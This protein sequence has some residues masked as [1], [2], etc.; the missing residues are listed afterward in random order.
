MKKKIIFFFFLL[1][2]LRCSNDASRSLLSIP[3]TAPKKGMPAS[4]PPADS[5]SFPLSNRDASEHRAVHK[6]KRGKKLLKDH[7]EPRIPEITAEKRDSLFIRRL[8]FLRASRLE[9]DMNEPVSRRFLF[10]P[11]ENQLPASMITLSGES[12]LSIN[13]DN[14][15]LDYTDRFYTNGIKIDLITPELRMN[16]LG[17]LM[18]PY[19]SGGKNYYGITVVQNMYTPSST[20][21]GGILYGDRPYSAYL[22]IGSF[23]I[24]MDPDHNFSQT[25]ELDIG[26]IGPKSFGEW[27]QRSFH[28]SV[29]TNHEPLGWEHQIKNDL[30]L[31]Y[32]LKMEKGIWKRKNADLTVISAA[33]AGTL[34]TNISGG[35]AFRAGLLNPYFMNPGVER[36]DKLRKT[37]LRKFQF[38][39]FI[40]GSGTVV[41]YDA[42][43][44][45]GLFNQTSPYTLKPKEISRVVFE[46]SS[47]ISVVL[48]GCRV[49]LEQFL[50]SPDFH[51]GWWHKWVH[52][53]LAFGL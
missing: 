32:S 16:P 42:T 10:L 35:G 30:V 48:N 51:N 28:R 12:F 22:Y 41:G 23:K 53:S 15:L 13:F 17:K 9:P 5:R 6:G 36:K 25:S 39:F 26:I 40:K 11:L 27:V 3:D 8:L 45:G 49:D 24:T 43:L 38:Y 34:Y 4:M 46:S 29:P 18:I 2:F 44:E 14:D 1:L 50:L 37:G 33:A 31:N 21:N 47:G 20:K 19:W 52:I 7:E